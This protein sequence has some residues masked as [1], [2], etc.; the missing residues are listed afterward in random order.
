MNSPVAARADL[1]GPLASPVVSG[2]DARDGHRRNLFIENVRVRLAEF[3][4]TRIL[5]GDYLI[6]AIRAIGWQRKSPAA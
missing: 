2:C 3:T 4:D 1:L 5:E 6:A